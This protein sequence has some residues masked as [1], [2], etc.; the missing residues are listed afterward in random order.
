MVPIIQFWLIL[1]H[2]YKKSQ[3]IQKRAFFSEH[4]HLAP[5]HVN[6]F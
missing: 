4:V 3:N 6:N 1:L 5:P 2:I